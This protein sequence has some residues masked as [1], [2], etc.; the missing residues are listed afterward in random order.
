MAPLITGPS[1]ILLWNDY[2]NTTFFGSSQ[3]SHLTH[4]PRRGEPVTPQIP[5]EVVLRG[6]VIHGSSTCG[7]VESHW[8]LAW[9]EP[10]CAVTFLLARC[11]RRSSRS[12][13]R[14]L[15]LCLSVCLSASLSRSL[16]WDVHLAT[17][18][19]ERSQDWTWC[20]QRK[21]RADTLW[22]SWWLFPDD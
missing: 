2:N 13:R 11:Q 7:S 20:A 16:M 5:V 3:R 15:P 19:L 12:G 10:L 8:A 1:A 17:L 14:S 4:V 18:C 21:W 22:L 6:V 9:N